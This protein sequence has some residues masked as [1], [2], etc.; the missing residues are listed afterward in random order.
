M[1]AAPG[2]KAVLSTRARI[3]TITAVVLV[4]GMG[5][6]LLLRHFG[7]ISPEPVWAW[8]VVLGAIAGFIA[9]APPWV[10]EL[11]GR[12]HLLVQMTGMTILAVTAIYLTGWGPILIT[13][14][15]IFPVVTVIRY[16][17]DLW[18]PLVAVGL[19]CVVL[20]QGGMAFHLV[21]SELAVATSEGVVALGIFI[22]AVIVGLT[23]YAAR[24]IEASGH[25]LQASEERFRSLIQY[26]SD[27]TMLVSPEDARII[28]VS[29]ACQELLGGS[30]EEL[31]GMTLFHLVHPEDLHRVTAQIA[32]KIQLQPMVQFEL[33]ISTLDGSEVRD[34]EAV[35]SDMHENPAVNGYVLNLRDISKRKAAEAQLEFAALHDTLT[36]LA[37]RALILDRTEQLLARSRRHDH[38]PAVLFIDLDN[39]KDVN[40]TLGHRAGDSLLVQL[41]DRLVAAVRESDTVGRMGGDEF[42][43]LLDGPLGDGE[44]E[45]IA[46]KLLTVLGEPV[47]LGPEYEYPIAVSAS[48]GIAIGRR[49]RPDD[50]IGDADIALYQAKAAGKRCSVVFA[51]AMAEAVANRLRHESDLHRAVAESEFYLVYQPLFD[52]DPVAVYG[53]EALLRWQHPERGVVSP[54]EFIPALEANGLILEVGRWVLGEACRQ[55]AEWERDGPQLVMSVNV[56]MA[57]FGTDR[58]VEDVAEAI[59]TA[60]CS[61]S[62]VILEITETMLMSDP[63]AVRERLR[64]L[65]DLGVRI[66]VDDFGTGY[67]SLAYLRQFPIDELKIDRTFIASI[68]ES[69]E[70]NV[71]VKSFVDLG[72]ALGIETLAEGI[73]DYTQL[74]ILQSVRCLRGQGFLVSRPLA[75]EALVEFLEVWRSDPDQGSLPRPA[76]ASRD[77]PA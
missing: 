70:S 27:T 65:K 5:N 39:F 72:Q 1:V 57:Q 62:R 4:L 3:A 74:E 44:P 2:A 63:A 31:V 29:P 42:V 61:P 35:I 46:A 50:L 7:L 40:D 48:I 8:V 75:A 34:I 6:T 17:P 14:I 64:L 22:Y 15:A 38:E 66:A 73:E 18:R 47:N 76:G 32:E 59:S 11:P 28:Y 60:G 36:G 26:A 12:R 56:S 51:P 9:A 33:Q 37:N 20:A 23:I 43:V 55:L 30:P 49:A 68:L 77:D 16:G 69:R 24:E 10:D 67:S 19:G 45:H 54:A 13:A 71:I 58:I 41:A 53:V 25:L 21:P 52:L